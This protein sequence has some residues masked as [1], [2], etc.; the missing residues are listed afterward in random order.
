MSQNAISSAIGIAL[1]LCFAF[2]CWRDMRRA[3]VA[4]VALA[5]I[6]FIRVFELQGSRIT[7]NL[8]LVEILPT[9]MFAVWWLGR[10]RGARTALVPSPV[11]LPLILMIPVALLS[12]VWNLGGADPN[13]PAQHV[14]LA[15]SIGQVLLIAWPVAIY[16]V[17]ASA[18]RDDQT[19]KTIVRMVVAMA[20]PSLALP[21]L[22]APWRAYVGW[23]IYFCLVA[24]PLCFAQSFE[25]RSILK[26]VGLWLIAIL[27]FVYGVSIGKAFLY[28]TTATALFVVAAIKGKRALLAAVPVAVGLYVLVAAATGSLLPGPL[29]DLVDVEVQQQSWGGRAGRVALAVDTLAIWIRHPLFGVGPG[30]SWPYMHRYSVID[31]PHNQ[32][33]NLL[34]ELGIVGLACFAWFIVAAFR[35]GV[36]ALR[37]VGDGFRRTLVTGWFALFV[38]MVVSGL[39]GDFI[40]H[41]IRNGG[42]E[43]FSGYYLQWV[44]LGMVAS[45]VDL[46]RRGE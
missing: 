27:P 18:V 9:V 44:F 7:Q 34:L 42:L 16:V 28:G 1:A 25:T 33:L 11:N 2:L 24:S 23:S 32:Y 20:V 29:K 14:K 22:P 6:L 12:L 41:S 4:F 38:G 37:R 26:K 31:T 43:M 21:L 36:D 10:V 46:E 45:L 35:M 8:L 40:F 3:V 30:N 5:W 17:S 15:V 39:T 19:M 13:V